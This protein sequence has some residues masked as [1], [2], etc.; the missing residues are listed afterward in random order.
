MAYDDVANDEENP[1]PGK[2]F[3]K[4][5]PNGPGVDVYDGCNIDYKGGNVTP[6]TFLSVL[7]GEGSGKVLR[8]SQDDHVFLNFI[9]HGARGPIAFPDGELHKK[10]LQSTIKE[11]KAKNMFK[12][13]VF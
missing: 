4:P 11:M 5:D 9:D 7:S 2:L 6:A 8:S 3:N 12:R 1:F 10:Q 13:L